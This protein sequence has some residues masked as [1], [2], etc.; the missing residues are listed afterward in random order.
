MNRRDLFWRAI[1]SGN[2]G[3][4]MTFLKEVYA[5]REPYLVENKHSSSSVML[6]G[7]AT[8][9]PGRAVAGVDWVN[10]SG[11]PGAPNWRLAGSLVI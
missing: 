9:G 7:I 5:A 8:F 11:E 2:P 4:A 1:S 6:L 3:H 10:D